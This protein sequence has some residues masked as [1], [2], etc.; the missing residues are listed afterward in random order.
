MFV[1]SKPGPVRLG[2]D[3]AAF[4]PTGELVLLAWKLTVGWPKARIDELSAS[5]GNFDHTGRRPSLGTA[6]VPR[7]YSEP[8]LGAC[9]EAR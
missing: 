1:A 5:F 2:L 4:L 9:S 3:R 6:S 8:R 7:E